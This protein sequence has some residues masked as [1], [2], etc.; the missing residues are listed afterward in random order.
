MFALLPTSPF[1]TVIVLP[2]ARTMS[3]TSN[4]EPVFLGGRSVTTAYDVWND[5]PATDAAEMFQW[6]TPNNRAND[7]PYDGFV[8]VTWM[9]RAGSHET[10]SPEASGVLIDTRIGV[11][12]NEQLLMFPGIGSH[13]PVE[14]APNWSTSEASASVRALRYSDVPKTRVPVT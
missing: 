6:S 1:L 8:T 9:E 3:F 7:T 11:P 4:V 14:V 5:N 13:V 10:Q 12:G 2:P